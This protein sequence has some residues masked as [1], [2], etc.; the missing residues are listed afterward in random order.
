MGQTPLY[1]GGTA[2]DLNFIPY[3]PLRAPKTF[4]IIFSIMDLQKND[5]IDFNFIFNND[6]G[7]IQ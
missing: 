6:L 1:S 4:S 3:S 2:E 5:N 7:T